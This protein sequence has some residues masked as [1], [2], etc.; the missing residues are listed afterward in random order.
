MNRQYESLPWHKYREIFIN[1]ARINL[2]AEFLQTHDATLQA[3][4][5]KYGVPPEVITAIIWELK[6]ITAPA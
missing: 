5:E 2:G 4:Y 1:D 3:A 6:H